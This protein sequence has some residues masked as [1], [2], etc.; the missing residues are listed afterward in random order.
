[1]RKIVA[2]FAAVIFAASLGAATAA[3][4]ASSER[5][6]SGCP[7]GV[8]PRRFVC[9]SIDEEAD[10]QVKIALL[11][12]DLKLARVKGKR[13]GC[14]AGAGLGVAGVVD[15]EFNL[16]AVPGVTVGV[17]CGWRF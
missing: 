6:P 17:T 1:M 11:E 8:D 3:P 9:F 2:N 5:G 10:R 4:T 15:E 16:R 12:R 14:V 13:V 7:P